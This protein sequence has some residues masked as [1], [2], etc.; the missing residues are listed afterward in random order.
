MMESTGYQIIFGKC[1]KKALRDTL[2]RLGH[3]RFG[4][5]PSPVEEELQGINDLDRL[6][7]MKRA[8]GR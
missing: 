1:E 5:L 4:S 2:L 8:C 3:Q 7:R 6:K